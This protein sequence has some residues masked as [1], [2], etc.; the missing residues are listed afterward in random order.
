MMRGPGPRG[1][2]GGKPPFGP[3]GRPMAKDA[4]GTMKRLLSYLG[5]YKLRLILVM[6][7]GRIAAQGTHE[8]LM[9]TCDIYRDVYESQQEGVSIGG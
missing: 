6:E 3:G 8:E 2:M 7:Q 5:A 1:P 4:K 9:K